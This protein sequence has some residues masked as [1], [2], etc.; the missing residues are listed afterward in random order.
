MSEVIQAR[1]RRSGTP[2]RAPLLVAAAAVLALGA[3]GCDTNRQTAERT[4]GGAAIGAAAGATVGLLSGGFLAA[5]ATGAAAGAVGGFVYDQ[6]E[7][8]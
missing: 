6:I 2:G 8:Q 1:P 3:A 5:T 7:K 4:A